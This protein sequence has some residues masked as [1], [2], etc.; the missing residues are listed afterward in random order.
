MT[1]KI[2]SNELIIQ[3]NKEIGKIISQK[4]ELVDI[5]GIVEECVASTYDNISDNTST[6]DDFNQTE[7]TE[8]PYDIS[9]SLISLALNP[10]K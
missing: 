8:L 1:V 7:Y 4:I 3:L 10:A 5:H 9:S 2:L 6:S